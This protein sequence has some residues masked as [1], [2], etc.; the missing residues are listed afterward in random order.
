MAFCQLRIPSLINFGDKIKM[1][2]TI[3]VLFC[4]LLYCVAGYFLLQKYLNKYY[5]PVFF[6]YNKPIKG[7][8]YY[9]MFNLMFRQ[10]CMGFAHGYFLEDPET[11]TILIL[12]VD[13]ISLII[14]VIYR[15]TGICNIATLLLF[16]YYLS[17]LIFDTIVLN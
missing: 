9:M 4:L 12:A 17:R 1:I 3:M 6:E 13:L 11:Q 14:L 10:F 16:T 15:K 2:I 5:W 8:C 7:S